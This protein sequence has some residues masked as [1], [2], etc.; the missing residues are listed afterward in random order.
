MVWLGPKRSDF[1]FSVAKE[2]WMVPEV[3]RS[4]EFWA[5]HFGPSRLIYFQ[6]LSR[7]HLELMKENPLFLEGKGWNGQDLS[8]CFRRCLN[9]NPSRLYR[10]SVTSSGLLLYW[11]LKG[12]LYLTLCSNSS[13]LLPSAKHAH[14]IIFIYFHSREKFQKVS[15]NGGKIY[16][17]VY[18]L[19]ITLIF[20]P[21]TLSKIF[22]LYITMMPL[23]RINQ[24]GK[25]FSKEFL[26]IRLRGTLR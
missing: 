2:I 22:I 11:L 1:W 4:N 17:I 18:C 10:T 3:M 7:P 24:I 20:F 26:F 5:V 12:V 9:S 16:S 23:G 21:K 13:I 25:S 14:Y 8:R 19:Y 15:V 6:I